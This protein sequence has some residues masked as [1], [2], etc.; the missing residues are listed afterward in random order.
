MLTRPWS[1]HPLLFYHKH[2]HTSPFPHQNPD[3]R[4]IRGCNPSPRNPRTHP[5]YILKHYCTKD[6]TVNVAHLPLQLILS[7]FVH[8]EEIWLRKLFSLALPK[9][10]DRLCLSRES[11]EKS[12]VSHGSQIL[13]IHGS[14][15]HVFA[16][17]METGSGEV[18]LFSYLP[19]K[20]I[21]RKDFLCTIWSAYD[22]NL[23]SYSPLLFPSP[24]IQC[25]G[26]WQSLLLM[27][28]FK[29]SS[30]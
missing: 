20:H 12:R 9:D 27:Q 14:T 22:L 10:E 21:A 5:Q 15:P 26:N 24:S 19:T 6:A 8:S 30:F 2:R 28:I 18:T 3:P 29:F 7:A 11:E 1:S 23:G 13:T 16:A 25:K 17:H 4:H